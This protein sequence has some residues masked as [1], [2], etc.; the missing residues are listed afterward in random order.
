MYPPPHPSIRHSFYMPERSGKVMGSSARMDA[1]V[2]DVGGEGVVMSGNAGVP[3]RIGVTE[4]LVGGEC[5]VGHKV[6]DAWVIRDG[7]VPPGMCAAAWNSIQ[8]YVVALRCGGVLPWSGETR[9]SA[10]CPDAANPVV[11][12]LTALAGE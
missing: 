2:H 3:V 10:C 7:I 11:F 5:P 6:G 8:P 12:E 9:M 4:I 1:E